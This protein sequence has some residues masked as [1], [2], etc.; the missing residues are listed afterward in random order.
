MFS[1]IYTVL[2]KKNRLKCWNV[3]FSMKQKQRGGKKGQKDKK[4]VIDLRTADPEPSKI[5][6]KDRLVRAIDVRMIFIFFHSFLLFN[7]VENCIFSGIFVKFFITSHW[8]HFF[9]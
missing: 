2:L 5:T 6:P 1:R 3:L 8:I 4:E 7:A 9:P